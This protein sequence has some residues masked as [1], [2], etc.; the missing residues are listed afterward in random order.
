SKLLYVVFSIALNEGA[1]HGFHRAL[2]RFFARWRRWLHGVAV[3]PRC[4]DL[5]GC[6]YRLATEAK[7]RLAT[8]GLAHSH[9]SVQSA[10]SGLL[11]DCN[12]VT[13][14]SCSPPSLRRRRRG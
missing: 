4:R 1:P 9:V 6:A 14:L 11:V 2:V 12:D 8:A 3:H 10:I 13:R 7:I 5:A